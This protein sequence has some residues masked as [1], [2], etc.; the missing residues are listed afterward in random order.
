MGDGMRRLEADGRVGVVA[1]RASPPR[2]GRL[3][4]SSSARHPTAGCPRMTRPSRRRIG[5]L[6][7]RYR[8][9]MKQRP[10][11]GGLGR[12]GDDG[13]HKTRPEKRAAPNNNS[14]APRRRLRKNSHKYRNR[15]SRAP[16][17]KQNV[18][19]A[20]REPSSAENSTSKTTA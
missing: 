14:G 5:V 10:S 1:G 18:A 17:S 4:I 20:I 8:R 7:A 6:A 16:R 19:V 12:S 3:I 2:P 11:L 15:R 9:K 13:D